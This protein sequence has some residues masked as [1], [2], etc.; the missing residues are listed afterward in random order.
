MVQTSTTQVEHAYYH[1][2]CFILFLHYILACINVW[3]DDP[4]D[5][6]SCSIVGLG[7]QENRPARV[8]GQLGSVHSKTSGYTPRSASAPSPRQ[9]TP[10]NTPGMNQSRPQPQPQPRAASPHKTTLST[11]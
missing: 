3:H 5:P 6:I 9:H 11:A 4:F 1:E 8:S 10:K 7:F 2:L